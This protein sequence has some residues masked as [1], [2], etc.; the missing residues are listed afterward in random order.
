V[1]RKQ[2]EKGKS[3]DNKWISNSITDWDNT[4]VDV[5]RVS[6]FFIVFGL[7]SVVIFAMLLFT[8][9]DVIVNKN[10]FDPQSL[11]IGVGGLLGGIST[12]LMGLGVY[13]FGDSRSRE[14]VEAFS[15]TVNTT[16]QG[17]QNGTTEEGQGRTNIAK[18]TT[19]TKA[20]SSTNVAV[21]EEAAGEFTEGIPFEDGGSGGDAGDSGTSKGGGRSGDF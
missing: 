4:T 12:V 6:V 10:Q 20:K 21:A 8:G 11:G 19:I 18:T 17:I 7:V 13:L 9:W 16:T 14:T 2:R 5:G 15:Q 1:A 3:N